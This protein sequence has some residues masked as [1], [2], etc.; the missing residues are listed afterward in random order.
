MGVQG[1]LV[2]RQIRHEGG[3]GADAGSTLLHKLKSSR[4]SQVLI[5]HEA[6]YDQGRAS[7]HAKRAV[8]QSRLAAG[9]ST[10]HRRRHGFYVSCYAV[11]RAVVQGGSMIHKVLCLC[12]MEARHVHCAVD[13]DSDAELLHQRT[14]HG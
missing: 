13:D 2:R 8:H 3:V 12:S 11:V 4:Q 5:P 14:V 7:A 6:G 9:F 10:P 1:A